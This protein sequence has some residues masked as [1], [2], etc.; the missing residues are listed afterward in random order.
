ME[1]A[2]CLLLND[3]AYARCP[4][5]QKY[6]FIYEWLKYLDRILTHTKKVLFY[7][8]FFKFYVF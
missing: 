7:F 8:F 5:P 1:Q 4:D 3:I 2:Q 6:I